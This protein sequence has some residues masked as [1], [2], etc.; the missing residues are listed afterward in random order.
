VKEYDLFIPLRDSDG[1]KLGPAKLKELQAEL[2]EHFGGLT[3]F[4]QANLGLWKFGDAV[5]RDEIVIF[6]VLSNDAESAAQFLRK[7]KSR[8]EAELK[9]DEILIVARDVES[10]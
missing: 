5:Y 3:N 7:I 10:L 8:L 2:V 1:Q 4:P 6:R 9:Q